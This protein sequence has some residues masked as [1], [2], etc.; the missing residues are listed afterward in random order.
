ML[1]AFLTRLKLLR[2]VE[3][4]L[5][6][7]TGW[8]LVSWHIS[9]QSGVPY[10]PTAML[11]T[12]GSRSGTLR[13]VPLFYFRDGDDFV[14]IASK[15]GAPAHPAWYPNLVATPQAWVRANRGRIAVTAEVVEGEE[16][17]RLWAIAAYPP[18]DEYQQRASPREIPVVRLRRR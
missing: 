14:L 5:V 13:S 16:R 1:F 15:G 3:S 9:R 18:Y 7:F 11:T 8:S 17:D 6:R 12:V 2:T 10:V 4:V